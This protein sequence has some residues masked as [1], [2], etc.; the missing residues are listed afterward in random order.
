[1]SSIEASGKNVEE[2]TRLA[3]EQLGVTEDDVYVEILDEG[4][5][6]FLGIGQTPARVKIT[7]KEDKSSGT[8]DKFMINIENKGNEFIADEEENTITNS[9]TADNDSNL[10]GAGIDQTNNDRAVLAQQVLQTI[11]DNIG[12]GG[13]AIIVKSDNEMISLN[14]EGG[15]PGVLIGKHGQTIN[16]IQYL[17]NTITNRHQLKH[18]RVS[19]D[20]DQYRSRREETLRNRAMHL[21]NE[22][23]Q[24]KQEAVLE[25]LDASERR[26]IHTALADDPD[27]RTYSEGEEPDRHVVISPKD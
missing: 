26:I 22:V 9:E 6:G 14:I 10:D 15:D 7:L 20:A 21:A 27:V 16:A 13:K 17:I 12:F 3:I 25:P 11:L 8:E 24:S 19:V 1:M 2:A 23:K 4:S 5:K 18:I